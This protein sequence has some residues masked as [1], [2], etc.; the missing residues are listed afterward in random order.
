MSISSGRTPLAAKSRSSSP[1]GTSGVSFGRGP[2]P[3]S[4]RMVRPSA[5][6]RYE[7]R[8]KRTLC[9]SVRCDSYGCQLSSGIVGKKLQRSN[10][11]VP[12]DKAMI[13]TSP[14]RITLSGM[15]AGSVP[16]AVT[17][18]ADPPVPY[19]RNAHVDA[20]HARGRAAA[21]GVRRRPA[22]AGADHDAHDVVLGLAAASP[23]GYRTA[24]L[25]QRGR[26]GHERS[27]E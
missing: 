26:E 7:P 9:S 14:T 27:R 2:S 25:G 20:D 13:S 15:V 8:L 17:L 24:G 22:G 16:H 6:I 19:W 4:I 18:P 10:S 23:H 3:V 11:R 5:R 1:H 12:S 21:G